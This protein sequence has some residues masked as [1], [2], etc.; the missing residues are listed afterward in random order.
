M[1]RSRI[2]K[3]LPILTIFC[4]TL[5]MYVLFQ[6]YLVKLSTTNLALAITFIVCC[7]PII[8]KYVNDYFDFTRLYMAHDDHWK[9][10]RMKLVM[11]GKELKLCYL[12][13]ALC[14]ILLIAMRSLSAYPIILCLGMTIL[15][16]ILVLYL[17]VKYFDYYLY[18]QKERRFR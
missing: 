14:P 2:I 8:I 1:Q 12:G 15:N 18:Y 10:Q 13:L 6:R 3:H 9:L 4:N 17:G 7:C 5:L 16:P 11:Y